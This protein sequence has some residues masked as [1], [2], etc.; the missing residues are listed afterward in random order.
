[1]RAFILALLLLPAPALAKTAVPPPE[2]AYVQGRLAAADQQLHTA[3]SL[4]ATIPA[5]DSDRRLKHRQFDIALLDGEK[6]AVVRLAEDIIAAGPQEGDS[7]LAVAIANSLVSLARLAVAAGDRDWRTYDRVLAGYAE[8]QQRW[9]EISAVLRQI[10]GA[11]GLAAD[12]DYDAA[13]ALLGPAETAA[14]HSYLAEHRAHILALAKRWPEAATAYSEMLA[15]EGADIPRLRIAAAAAALEA[16]RDDPQWRERGIALIAGGPAHDPLLDIARARIANDPDMRGR[17]LGSVI[18][19]PEQGVAQLLLR[20]S[21]DLGRGRAVPPAL[22]FARLATF[23]DPDL[24]EA[25]F[26]SSGLLM[27]LDRAELALA[28]LEPAQKMDAPWGRMARVQRAEIF[29]AQEKWDEARAALLAEAQRPDAEAGDWTRLADVERRAGNFPEAAEYFSRALALAGD[30]DA[31]MKGQIYFLRGSA[32]EQAGQ[33]EKAEPD[34]RQALALD[35]DNPIYLNYLGYSLLERGIRL[36]EG[37]E[38]VARAY[39]GAPENGAI[40][41]SMGWAAYITGDYATA[42]QLLEKARAAEPADPTVSDHLG[43]A[44]WRTG[45]RIEARHAWNAARALNPSEKQAAA[46]DVKLD[47]G[48]DVAENLAGKAQ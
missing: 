30:S 17:K 14:A 27:R 1:M 40:I 25:W 31:G 36:D 23:A 43:D 44:Y 2:Y 7:G 38:L 41:D 29:A 32:W 11:W 26:V 22:G 45:R 39:A 28:A 9:G 48:L 21:I 6:K 37:R 35:P 19:R 46:L 5:E 12:R 24:P 8:P 42:V 4:F 13:L 33:W 3:A 18:T 20:V 34:L 10:L 47:Y 15:T 16:G